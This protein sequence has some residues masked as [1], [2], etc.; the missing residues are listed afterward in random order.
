MN[1]TRI[2]VFMR[3]LLLVASLC[4][5]QAQAQQYASFDTSSQ[6]L[7]NKV[8]A[9][10][11]GASGIG[12]PVVGAPALAGLESWYLKNQLLAFR[13][14][15]RG[16]QKEYV[17][18][19]EMQASVARLSDEEIEELVQIISTWEPVSHGDTLAGDTNR[20]SELY[21][22]CAACHGAQGQGNQALG[23]PKLAGREDWY[24]LRQLKL[25]KSGYRGSHPED[26]LGSQ[27]RTGASVLQNENDM[28]AVVAF[29]NTLD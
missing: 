4:S 3:H 29:L 6:N 1:H 24:L 12:N 2:Q 23:A 26:A 27:M 7:G 20:G 10:C 15:Y 14:E 11:H 25:F 8:C 17:P 22:G 19:L 28:I 21:L 18:G 5:L 13:N 9:T 16:T